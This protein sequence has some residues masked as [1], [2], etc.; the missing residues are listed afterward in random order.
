MQQKF[1]NF[2]RPLFAGSEAGETSV[3]SDFVIIILKC[4]LTENW[5]FQIEGWVERPNEWVIS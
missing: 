3:K 5:S 2:T 4:K 1:I